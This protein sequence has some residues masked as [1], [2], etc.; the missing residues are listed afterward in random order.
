MI[1]LINLQAVGQ[2]AASAA[3]CLC[4]AHTL[5]MAAHLPISSAFAHIYIH[6]HTNMLEM[7][8]LGQLPLAHIDKHTSL[9][10]LQPPNK[11]IIASGLAP[12]DG[13]I[14]SMAFANG[15]FTEGR[16]NKVCARNQQWQK[17]ESQRRSDF[18]PW[19]ISENLHV[20]L[21]FRLQ[22]WKLIKRHKLNVTV[23]H[24]RCCGF[25]FSLRAVSAAVKRRG[26]KL[27]CVSTY[28]A[29]EIIMNPQNI[30]LSRFILPSGS[31][32]QEII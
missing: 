13:S 1:V 21:F 15:H 25:S 6:L 3:P 8:S 16:Q 19:Q 11:L 23:C 7:T 14:F 5:W 24:L 31:S 22:S 9:Q 18:S 29:G 27:F 17:K 32:S 20:Q 2:D 12:Y 26:E 28:L 30:F 10:R 4:S